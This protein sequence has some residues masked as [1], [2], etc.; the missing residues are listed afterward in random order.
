MKGK[1]DSATIMG[2]AHLAALQ[3]TTYNFSS[4]PKT[5]S[6]ADYVSYNKVSNMVTTMMEVLYVQYDMNLVLNN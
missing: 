2:M 6:F 1:F 4:L 5:I 3:G